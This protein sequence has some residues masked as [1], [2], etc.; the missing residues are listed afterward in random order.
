MASVPE[1]RWVGRHHGLAAQ[2]QKPGSALPRPRLSLQAS[3]P[4]VIAAVLTELP[5]DCPRGAHPSP[6]DAPDDSAGSATR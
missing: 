1:V 4:P 5:A 6:L 2:C 3:T